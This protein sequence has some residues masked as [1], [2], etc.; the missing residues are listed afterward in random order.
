MGSQLLPPPEPLVANERI[1]KRT[2]NALRQIANGLAAAAGQYLAPPAAK[3]RKTNDGQ[4]AA[5]TTATRMLPVVLNPDPY[6]AECLATMRDHEHENTRPSL[7]GLDPELEEGREI[8]TRWLVK[9]AK[10]LRLEPEVIHV[11]CNLFDRHLAHLPPD[12]VPTAPSLLLTA[13]ACL[14]LAYKLEELQE[15]H[16]P[17]RSS[18]PV[19]ES[20][21]RAAPAS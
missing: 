10:N 5:D 15:V 11:T 13:V 1:A 17:K 12:A 14:N 19:V 4:V 20:H 6:G 18:N 8:C 2:R 9:T 7:Q 21:V 16:A 3:R